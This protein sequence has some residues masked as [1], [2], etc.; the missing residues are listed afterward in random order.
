MIAQNR[1]SVVIFDMIIA[2]IM[3]VIFLCLKG[4]FKMEK[5]EIVLKQAQ[6]L[7]KTTGVFKDKE[8]G[9]DI[10]YHRFTVYDY[11]KDKF[12]GVSVSKEKFN[13]YEER[14]LYDLNI[15][16]FVGEKSNLFKLI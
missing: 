6:I 7:K 1:K 15:Q 10:T 13:L 9:N 4:G 2:D 3:S 14:K 12:Y 16:L 8:K 11:A 5:F